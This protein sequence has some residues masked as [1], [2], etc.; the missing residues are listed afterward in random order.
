[1]QYEYD[2]FQRLINIWAPRELLNYAS[3]VN[4]SYDLENRVAV[5]THNTD[6]L[7]HYNVSLSEDDNYCHVVDLST[8]DTVPM[9]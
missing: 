3:S 1:M 9:V 8:R 6:N 4:Y 7:N 2:Q 5:T